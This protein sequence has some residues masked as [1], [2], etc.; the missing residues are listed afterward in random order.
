MYTNENFV[1]RE[2]RV[3]VDCF[4][5]NQAEFTLL[6]KLKITCGL[7]FR[8]VPAF[9]FLQ[10]NLVRQS[11]SAVRYSLSPFGPVF[12]GSSSLGALCS[13]KPCKKNCQLAKLLAG[14]RDRP[15]FKQSIP[16]FFS[17]ALR[18]TRSMCKQKRSLV[19][20]QS[21][22]AGTDL[23]LYDF[24]LVRT[25]EHASSPV[26]CVSRRVLNCT[27]HR[28]WSRRLWRV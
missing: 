5:F 20:I 9:L 15:R 22:H 18:K 11:P 24:I 4:P 26:D 21:A 28:A 10:Q 19:F 7:K 12:D 25:I 6:P 13:L 17:E 14:N 27:A 16:E 3:L 1:L 8:S 2:P 23:D